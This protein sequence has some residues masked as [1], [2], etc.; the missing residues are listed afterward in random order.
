MFLNEL[1]VEV[2]KHVSLRW[3]SIQS[4]HCPIDQPYGA[5]AKAM[6]ERQV[7]PNLMDD[8]GNPDSAI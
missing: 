7:Y 1:A 2:T 3:Q 4:E 8:K 5:F 6:L